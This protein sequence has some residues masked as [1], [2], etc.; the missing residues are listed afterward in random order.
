MQD[1]L[2]IGS[3]IL[4]AIVFG[5]LAMMIP[6]HVNMEKEVNAPQANAPSAVAT[7]TPTTAT[8]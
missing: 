3:N 7:K 2:P 4:A 6:G 5:T 8:R 1:K